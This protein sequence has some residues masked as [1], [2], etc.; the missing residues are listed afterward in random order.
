[1]RKGSLFRTSGVLLF[2]IKKNDKEITRIGMAVTKKYG[3]A[4]K[5]NRAK[6]I[7][8]DTFRTS[9]FKN[10]GY[11]IVIAMNLKKIKKEK[12]D[13]PYIESMINESIFDAFKKN[14]R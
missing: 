6:R 13:F 5:R 7:M 9:E 4:C 2:Y 14:L 3:K 12:L 10:H 1:M 11:D 8:R